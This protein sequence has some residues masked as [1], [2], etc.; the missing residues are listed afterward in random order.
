VTSTLTGRNALI[1]GAAQGIGEAIAADLAARGARVVI[2]DINLRG[3]EDVAAKIL[4]TGG[5]AIAVTMDISDPAAIATTRERIQEELRGL[6]ILVNNAGI[7]DFTGF[8]GLTIEHFR[9]VMKVNLEGAVHVSLG[10]LGLL[11]ASKVG[12]IVHITSIQ[13][14]RG[15]PGAT[16]YQTAKGALVN[17]TRSMACDLAPYGILVNAIAPGFVDTAMAAMPDGSHEHQQEWFREIY[18]RWGRIPLRRAALPVDIARAVSFFCGD[19]CTYVTGQTL[20]VD[21]G[22]SATF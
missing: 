1:T 15:W 20:M 5:D 10:L 4:E 21:G 19:D 18:L 2:S 3:A 9:N 14:V 13:G 8:D 12:R 17:L 22:L 6:D 7:T 11:R 16:A